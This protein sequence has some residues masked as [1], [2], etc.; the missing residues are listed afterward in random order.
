MGWL[1]PEQ[2]VATIQNATLYGCFYITDPSGR[3]LALRSSRD[4]AVWN[5]PGGDVENDENPLDTA[6]REFREE[7]G[8]DIESLRPDLVE[9]PRL[10]AV[11]FASPA[12]SWPRAKTGFVFDGGC[13]SEQRIHQIVLQPDEHTEWRTHTIDDWQPLM[14]PEAF[15]RLRLVDA[16]RR[17]SQTAFISL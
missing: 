13:L 14:A 11:T 6:V 7:T 16:A 10:L 8:H 9:R 5:W 17:S 1:P 4:P 15:T 2:Y 3:S 12:A